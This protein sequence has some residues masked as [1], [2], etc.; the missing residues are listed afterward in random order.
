MARNIENGMFILKLRL[1]LCLGKEK[2]EEFPTSCQGFKNK[3]PEAQ[4][5]TCNG[6]WKM[7]DKLHT[8]KTMQDRWPI[9]SGGIKSV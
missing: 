8:F 1:F 5:P 2:R 7:I 4:L 3:W 6:F 9:A